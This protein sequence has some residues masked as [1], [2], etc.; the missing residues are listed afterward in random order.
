MKKIIIIIML[1]GTISFSFGQV[2]FQKTSLSS[3]GGSASSGSL[4]MVYAL[5]EIGVQEANAGNNLLSEGFIGPDVSSLV[6]IEDYAQLEGL[7]IYP[8]PVQDYLNI[9]LPNTGNYEVHLFD[10]TGKQV[11]NRM[12]ENDYQTSYNLSNLKTGIYLL[13]VI[14]RENQKAKTIKLQKK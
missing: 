6:G 8:N 4:Y 12:I 1:L 14:N 3:G 7:N 5:G 13:S 10:M 9:E 11:L 2:A